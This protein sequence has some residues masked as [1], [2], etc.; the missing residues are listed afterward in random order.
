MNSNP[1]TQSAATSIPTQFRCARVAILGRPN[2]GKSTL[3]NALMEVSLSATSKRPQTTR[4]NIRGVIQHY[5]GEREW[6]GQLVLVDTP[7]V[8][9]KKGLLDRSMHMQVEGALKD[10]DVVLWVAD[11]RNFAKDLRD[12]EMKRPGSDKLAGWLKHR[13]EQR[14][15][16]R[17]ILALSKVDM[18]NKNELLPLIAKAVEVVPE[19][20]DVIPIAAEKGLHSKDSNLDCL[21]KVLR[22]AAPKQPPVFDEH[23]WTDLNE[24]QLIQNLVREAIFRQ[25]HEE[26]PYQADCTIMQYIEPTEGRRMPE[27]DATIWV[28]KDSL[29]PIL[30]GA[31]GSRIKEIGQTV[32]ARYKDITGEDIVL[33]MFVKVVDKWDSRAQSL[34][35]LGYALES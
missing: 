35:E 23:T 5:N 21:L 29:K 4:S 16:V 8:N 20:S 28:A 6:D 33:R 32:R 24:R 14:G 10:V 9:F 15:E 34:S 30:V 17:W 19:F 13:L 25:V 26:V 11:A 27:V 12:I 1:E 22:D 31:Q 3:L 18:V 7:G 2:A